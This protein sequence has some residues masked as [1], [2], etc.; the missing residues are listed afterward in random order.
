[1]GDFSEH[2]SATGS[3]VLARS[4]TSDGFLEVDVL[5]EPAEVG[6]APAVA[7]LAGFQERQRSGREN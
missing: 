5:P 1:M 4:A 2:M 6:S 7:D 3:P